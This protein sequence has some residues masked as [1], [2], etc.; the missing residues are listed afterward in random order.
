MPSNPQIGVLD[1][2]EQYY[3]FSSKEAAEEFVLDP[4]LYV[5]SVRFAACV[6]RG[7]YILFALV[8]F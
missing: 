5:P 6:A 7:L 1:Y 8:S 4:D 2:K 3:A